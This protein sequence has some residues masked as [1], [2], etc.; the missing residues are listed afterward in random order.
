MR[1]IKRKD[2]KIKIDLFRGQISSLCMSTFSL[3]PSTYRNCALTEEKIFE[4]QE[5]EKTN[6]GCRHNKKVLHGIL[7]LTFRLLQNSS[8]EVTVTKYD[9]I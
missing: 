3:R 4:S 2:Y 9:K 1:M 6:S 5:K 8:S 7:N